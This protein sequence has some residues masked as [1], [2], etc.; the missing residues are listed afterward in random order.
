MFS[1][2]GLGRQ[3]GQA[4]MAGNTHTIDNDF[5]IDRSSQ[6]QGLFQLLLYKLKLLFDT[7]ASWLTCEGDL[8]IQV[9][10]LGCKAK[11]KQVEAVEKTER[12][13]E[14]LISQRRAILFHRC[15]REKALL[16]RES[17]V[18]YMTFKFNPH[19]FI[20]ICYR[21]PQQ[22]SVPL[23]PLPNSRPLNAV[24]SCFWRPDLWPLGP[25]SILHWA[26]M[27]E[28]QMAGFS[29][30]MLSA[31]TEIRTGFLINSDSLNPRWGSVDADQ[32][33]TWFEI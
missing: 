21:D 19:P 12:D 27:W 17:D 31:S 1:I 4:K 15:V 3:F 28:L 29:S 20:N 9:C 33:Y 8:A 24:I 23:T 6:E 13:H 18:I 14:K 25:V 16:K 11:F 5:H 7:T 10:N 30:L 22:D 26:G 2:H 32:I